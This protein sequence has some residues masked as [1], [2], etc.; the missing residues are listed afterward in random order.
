ML[1]IPV[2][3]ATILALKAAFLDSLVRLSTMASPQFLSPFFT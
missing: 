3:T 2:R 1:L